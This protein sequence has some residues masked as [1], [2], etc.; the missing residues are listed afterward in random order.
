MKPIVLVLP[1]S[2]RSKKNSKRIFAHGKM[3]KVLPSL[4]YVAWEQAARRAVLLQWKSKQLLS[5]DLHISAE[6]RFA[7]QQPDLSGAMESIG[8]CLEGVIYTNDRQIK[9]WDGSRLYHD[10][11]DALTIV[12][13]TEFK[14]GMK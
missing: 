14:G 13:I 7:G 12:T 8:D 6:I 11:D 4:A 5:C 2:I 9:S 10:T 1:G 3:K